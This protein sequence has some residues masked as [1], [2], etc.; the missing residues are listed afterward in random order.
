MPVEG[1]TPRKINVSGVGAAVIT[2]DGSR[3]VAYKDRRL[4]V[5]DVANGDESPLTRGGGEEARGMV[6]PDGR[7]VSFA[8]NYEGHWAFYVAPFEEGVPV[9]NPIK[10]VD[11]SQVGGRS[12]QW[13]TRDG[14]LTFGMYYADGHIYRV[15][16]DPKSGQAVDA[17]VQLTQDTEYNSD[18]SISPDG[19]QIAYVYLQGG[20]KWGVASMDTSGANERPLS[21]VR[22]MGQLQWRSP[23]ELLL[24]KGDE[25]GERWIYGLDIST[26]LM[27]KVVQVA[28]YYWH[29]VPGRNEIIHYYPNEV[30]DTSSA[31][32]MSRSLLDA[33]EVVVARIEH[34]NP[35]LLI[36]ADGERIAYST[37]R[38]V[39]GSN[40]RLSDLVVMTTTGED[41]RTL[42]PP[43]P[44]VSATPVGWSPDGKFLLYSQAGARVMNV[45]TLES[46]PLH[47]ATA[48]SGWG[49]A[50][51]SPD[52]T[53]VVV[54]KR[55]QR[56]DRLAWEGVTYDAVVSLTQ[57]E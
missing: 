2:P 38:P 8:A 12:P 34:L 6:S 5:I 18:P 55:S 4:V 24:Q 29:Y 15:D 37:N 49:E 32:L 44:G 42:I 13:W 19:R 56:R 3:L 11:V 36:S 14:L 20:T 25:L 50:D 51:W 33:S 28:G 46:W 30:P 54:V 10:L 23:S 1:G 17:P 26:G 22:P 43:A 53:F 39:E 41:P 27:E 47:P 7:L 21:A 16:I 57:E 35:Y 31:E 48:E 9:R 45:E 40:E 52:G